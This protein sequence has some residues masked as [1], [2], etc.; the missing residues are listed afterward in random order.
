MSASIKLVATDTR[1]SAGFS[2]LCPPPSRFASVF[3]SCF[4]TCIFAPNVSFYPGGYFNMLFQHPELLTRTN[5]NISSTIFSMNEAEFLWYPGRACPFCLKCTL[6]KMLRLPRTSNWPSRACV[7]GE[8]DMKP[9]GKRGQGCGGTS[10]KEG[11]WGWVRE[12]TK[13]VRSTN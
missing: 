12:M 9:G 5:L 2:L 6:E 1:P 3:K 7:T 8:E 11:R 4:A 10:H 13:V